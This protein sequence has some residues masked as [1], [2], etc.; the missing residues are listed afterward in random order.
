MNKPSFKSL[1]IPIA[2]ILPLMAVVGLMIAAGSGQVTAPPSEAKIHQVEVVKLSPQDNYQQQQ[3]AYGRLESANLSN[4]GFELAGKVQQIWV[5]EG[6]HIVAGQLI[7]KLDTKR[8]DASM[9]ELEAALQSAKSDLRLAKQS[10]QRVTELVSRNLE[11]TQRLNEVDESTQ[12]AKALVEQTQARINTLL[13][14][15]EKSELKASFEGT[16]V[17]RPI[18][19]STVVSAGQPVVVVQQS[20]AYDARIAL[21]SDQAFG[22]TVGQKH[23]LIAN[24]INLS[25]VIKS[26]AKTRQMDTRTIDVIFSIEPN[27]HPLLPGDLIALTYS[28]QVDESGV[29]VPKQ[30]LSSGIRGLW[31]LFTVQGKGQQTVTS[32]SVEVLFAGQTHSY[33]RG[34][35]SANDWMVVSGAHR[36]VPGQIVN[37]VEAQTSASEERE[38]ASHQ[39]KL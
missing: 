2:I 15:L 26:I 6:D 36:L 13:V 37:A 9:K 29:W 5:D 30:A 23:R 19:P 39:G 14:E 7:A 20:S 18:D 25:G 8:L 10:Q 12:V 28:K 24:G 35:L 21:S 38:L 22:L 16:I 3:L 11:S 31:T 33:V 4:L 1:L 17:S 27:Q 34:P 32:R